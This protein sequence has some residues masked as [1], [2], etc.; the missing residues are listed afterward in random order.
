MAEAAGAFYAVET[1]VEGAVAAVKGIYDPTL[2][3]KTDLVPV[4]DVDLPRYA[5]TVSLVKGRAYVFGGITSKDGTEA[6]TDNDIHVV[7]LPI[8]ATEGSDYK[9]IPSGP[10]SPPARHGHSAAVIDDQI[11]IYGGTS[12]SN[13]PLDEDG[14]VWAF[15]TGTATWTKLS[16][17]STSPPPPNRLKHASVATSHPQKPQKRADE[18]LVPQFES[19]PSKHV[20]EPDAPFSYGTL[21]THGGVLAGST[22]S[23]P[24]NDVWSFD[25]SS[26]TWSPLPSPSSPVRAAPSPSLTM[27]GSRLYIYAAGG[28]QFMDLSTSTYSDKGGDGELGVSP[29]GPWAPVTRD[30]SS[31]GPGERSGS[32]VVPITTGQ[33]RKYLALM[34]GEE[35]SAVGESEG[36]G[37]VWT[38]QLQPEGMSAASFKDAARMAVKKGTG[39]KEWAEVRYFDSEGVMVQEGQEGR[40]IGMRT[41][42]A[43]DKS[44]DEDGSTVFVHGGKESG[45]V[46]GDGVLVTFGI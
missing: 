1:F 40:G 18:G 13:E 4:K 29:L 34:G 16:P 46:R 32:V 2:P 24:L 25:I 44:R 5:H 31:E 41:G 42:F 14:T 37:D 22:G 28:V 36:K 8:S 9:R 27:E 10:D 15:S 45:K 21:I 17:S 12:F 19:D 20:P 39:E 6:L 38:L 33:G 30:S 26:R 23:E 43:A 11:Y 3:L 35:R 7:I